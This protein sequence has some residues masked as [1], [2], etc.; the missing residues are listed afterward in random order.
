MINLYITRDKINEYNPNQ[1]QISDHSYRLL[2]T[3]GSGSGLK[4][5]NDSEAFIEYS[6]NLLDVF[7][8]I[9]EYNTE[10]KCKVLIVFDDVITMINKNKSNSN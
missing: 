5:Y 3:G 2:I 6:N 10:R 4:Y 9:E 8:N 7:K 1:Q